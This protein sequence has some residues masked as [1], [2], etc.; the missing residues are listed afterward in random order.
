MKA[1]EPRIILITPPPINE[2]MLEETDRKRG[3][4]ERRRA[5]EYTKQYADAS[6]TVGD[7]LGVA[8]LDLWKVLMLEAGWRDGETLIGSKKR[9]PVP[10]FTEL[11][12]DG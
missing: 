12:H 8:V 4:E 6:R 10:R 3:I 5:A 7:E 11:T 1:H 2:Y 9:Q